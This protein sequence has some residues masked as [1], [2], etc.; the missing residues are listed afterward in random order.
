VPQPNPDRINWLN[1]GLMVLSCGVAVVAPFH[2]FLLAYAI[3][4]PLHYLTEI[5]WLHDRQYF[6]PG[7]RGRRAWVAL[8]VVAGGLLGYGYISS[9]VLHKPVPPEL[10]IGSLFLVF[11]SAAV[12]CYVR[13]PVNALAVLFLCATGVVF[14]STSPAYG[15]VAYLLITIIHVFVFTACFLLYGAM[16]SHRPSGY[17]SVAVF[18]VCTAIT[19][20]AG[21]TPVLLSGSMRALYAPFEQLNV[22]LLGMFGRQSLSV[23]APAAVGI[24]RFIAFAYTYHYLNWFSKTSIIRWHEVTRTRA[25]AIVV[26]WLT[27]VSIYAYNYRVGFAIFFVLSL[28]HV[29][30]EFPLNHQ[31][32]VG[33]VKN[34]TLMRR[35]P[36]IAAG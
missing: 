20:M 28:L 31:S 19:F 13:H 26:I 27:G 16:K 25:L 34:L 29:M 14:F 32:F 9:D 30:L 3:L 21:G 5:S 1:A 24:M 11:A 23:Y 6:T 10:E 35:R 2:L 7:V 36:A 22:I 17:I 4:G 15:I 18:V 12:V 33:I 8:V